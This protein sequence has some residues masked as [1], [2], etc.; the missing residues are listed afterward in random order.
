MTARSLDRAAVADVVRRSV[1]EVLPDLTPEMIADDSVRLADVG[2]NS[3]DRVE[4][5]MLSLES[6]SLAVPAAELASARNLGGLI[7]LLTAS[8][9]SRAGATAR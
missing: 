4:I 2:A 1:R 9:A 6:L 5:V 3:V 8:L 7:D